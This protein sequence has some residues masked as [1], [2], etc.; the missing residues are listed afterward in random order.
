MASQLVSKKEREKLAKLFK[1]MD[2]SGD[3][4]ID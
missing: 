4:V 2:K 1:N 3:G